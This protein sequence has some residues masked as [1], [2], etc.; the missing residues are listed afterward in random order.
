MRPWLI[1]L[2]AILFLGG[3][4]FYYLNNIPLIG[5]AIPNE[6]WWILVLFGVIFGG[7][8]LVK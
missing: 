5:L 1:I 4:I 6:C 3:A 7:L 8:G 2:G